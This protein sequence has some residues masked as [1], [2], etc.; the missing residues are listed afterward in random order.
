M[1]YE[2][3][4]KFLVRD[5]SWRMSA[6][7]PVSIRQAYLARTGS[8]SLRI[9]IKDERI[10]TLTV[11]SAGAEIRRLEFEYEIPLADAKAM[12]DLREGGIV[13]KLRYELPWHGSVWEIDVF[14]GENRGLV[15]AEIE[16]P[17][18]NKPFEKPPWL[19]QEVT[20]DTRYSNAGLAATPFSKW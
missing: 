19:G 9:R 11:K 1:A 15:I 4:R 14:E 17:D 8:M 3:E 10:G 6:G 7:T 16:L 2:I 5:E 12:A 18:E 13:A 20:A